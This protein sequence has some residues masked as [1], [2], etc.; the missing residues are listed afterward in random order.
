MA[1]F[2]SPG[3]FIEEVNTSGQQVEAVGTSTMATVGWTERGPVD[4]ATVVTGIDDFQRK[5]GEYTNDSRVPVSVQAFFVNGGSRAYVVRVV[6]T[7]SAEG[8][9][10]ITDQ[11]LGE[12]LTPVGTG[13]SPQTMTDTLA[14]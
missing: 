11:I 8:E 3:I 10:C 4:T 12:T 6:P 13:V 2:L 7:D 9:S 5:F 14:N 1:E